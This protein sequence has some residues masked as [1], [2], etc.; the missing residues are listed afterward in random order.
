MKTTTKPVR[1]TTWADFTIRAIKVATIKMKPAYIKPQESL[2]QKRSISSR[3]GTLSLDLCI[4]S[5]NDLGSLPSIKSKE[6]II[7]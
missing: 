6:N 3:A 4:Y 1:T 7:S 2:A 5:E